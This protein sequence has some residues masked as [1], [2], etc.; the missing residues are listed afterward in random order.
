MPLIATK[1]CH[2]DLAARPSNSGCV[3]Y[4]R[5]FNVAYEPGGKGHEKKGIVFLWNAFDRN[6]RAA[7]EGVGLPLSGMPAP[8]RIGFW[9]RCLLLPPPRQR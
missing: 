5:E 7:S 3:Q 8:N 4:I 6:A 9:C 2:A 1:T